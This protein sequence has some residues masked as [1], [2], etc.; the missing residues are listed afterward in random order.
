M[1]KTRNSQYITDSH[2]QNHIFSLKSYQSCKHILNRYSQT[3][4]R[5]IRVKIVH[6]NYNIYI[7]YILLSYRFYSSHQTYNNKEKEIKT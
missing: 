4:A 3:E 7:N 6:E 5:E 2:Q 1:I